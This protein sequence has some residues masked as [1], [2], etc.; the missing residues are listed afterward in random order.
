MASSPAENL[1]AE[2][3]EAIVTPDNNEAYQ[4]RRHLKGVPSTRAREA[5][6]LFQQRIP[7]YST[8]Y[9]DGTTDQVDRLL[10]YLSNVPPTKRV[11]FIRRTQA[12]R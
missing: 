11:L 4:L 5:L 8:V 9:G 12:R 2:A 6:R 10:T 3:F 1:I 7:E